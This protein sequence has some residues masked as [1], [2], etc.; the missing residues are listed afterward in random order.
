MSIFPAFFAIY[1]CTPLVK[2]RVFANTTLSLFYEQSGGVYME[3]QFHRYYHLHPKVHKTTIR[4]ERKPVL[5]LEVDW[6]GT[7]IAF[8]DDESGKMS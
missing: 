5:S 1:R 8:F 6:A 7:R 4:L 2:V 3:T